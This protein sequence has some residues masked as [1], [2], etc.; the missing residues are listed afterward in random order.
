MPLV[1]LE[2][3]ISTAAASAQKKSPPRAWEEL[4]L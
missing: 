1:P 3:D 4:K 2:A